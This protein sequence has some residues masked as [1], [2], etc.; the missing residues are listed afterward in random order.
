M[1]AHL[2][3]GVQCGAEVDGAGDDIHFCAPSDLG[4][5]AD[6]E[7]RAHAA[8]VGR[9]L[10]PLHVPIPA[11]GVGAVVG[12]ID[13]DGVV[14]QV[15]RFQ[16]GENPADVAVLVLKHGVDAPSGVQVFV[17][18]AGCLRE[19]FGLEPLPILRRY[20]KR[21]VR[22]RE[23]H[24]AQEGPALVAFDELE[25][26]VGER[27]DDVPL[28]LHHDSVVFEWGVEVL[29]P[30]AGSVA[31]EG[32]EPTRHRV[33][34]PLAAVMPFAE[35]A[36]DVAGGL[37]RIG[38]GFFARI[39]PFLAGRDAG[40]TEPAVIASGEELGAGGG[41]DGLDEE[42]FEVC[43]VLSERVDVRSRQLPIPVEGV[44]TPARIIRQE[45]DHVGAFPGHGSAAG[46]EHDGGEQAHAI[47][48]GDSRG[49]RET[50]P[51]RRGSPGTCSY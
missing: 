17:L 7:G 1:A 9:A 30:V 36:G 37:E 50:H 39:H 35:E 41:T 40:N 19:G 20:G 25:C 14:F 42:T 3:Q 22:R 44:V 29:P 27:I 31:P 8:F 10:L 26:L 34:G 13:D 46:Q 43:A 2:S 23:R 21:R 24:E 11:G 6:E 28:G 15:E 47:S 45:D 4:G 38:E 18:G 5:P 51:W 33:V 32:V 49:R 12:E 16:L 48:S